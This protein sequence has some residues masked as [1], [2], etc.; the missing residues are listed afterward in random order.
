MDL[1]ESKL[2]DLELRKHILE[3]RLDTKLR[4]KMPAF[5]GK[6]NREQVYYLIEEVKAFRK[7]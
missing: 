6:L 5:S 4:P 2:S 1:A 7:K 3:G